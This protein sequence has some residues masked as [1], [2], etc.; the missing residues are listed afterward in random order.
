M[1]MDG[2]VRRVDLWFDPVCPYS[3][4]ASRWLA[5]V[6]SRVPL[7]LGLHVMSL[8]IAHED[9][10][11]PGGGTTE[12]EEY[13]EVIRR[14]AGPSRVAAAVVAECGEAA[15]PAF[16]EAFGR[17]IFDRPR[18]PRPDEY[19]SAAVTALERA[20][21]PAALVAAGDGGAYDEALRAS[22]EAGVPAV[23]GRTAGTP[24]T[25]LAGTAFFG[26]V[27]NA[28]PRG[29][30]AVRLFEGLW[31]VASVP[32]FHEFKRDRLAPPVFD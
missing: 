20:G 15:L 17:A 24:T 5:E 2:A 14:S 12:S 9:P 11:G 26:P 8:L 1:I 27:L 19:R 22:H 10:E 28:I 29:E 6:A 7:D 3:W 18:F 31:A 21:L 30:S 16:Y 32:G 23:G 25:H 13:L 4:T